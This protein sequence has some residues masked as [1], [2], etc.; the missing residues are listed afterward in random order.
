[1]PVPVTGAL[2]IK[3]YKYGTI[4]DDKLAELTWTPPACTPRHSASNGSQ[5]EIAASY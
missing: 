5:Y 3:L 4:Y 2:T 1:M